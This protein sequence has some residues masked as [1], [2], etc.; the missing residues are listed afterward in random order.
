MSTREKNEHNH[1][2]EK[3]YYRYGR[4][5]VVESCDYFKPEVEVE[6][7]EEAKWQTVNT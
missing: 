2:L 7:I 6:N 5:C 1:V 4:K 3:D